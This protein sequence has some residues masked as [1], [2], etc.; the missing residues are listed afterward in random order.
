M[1]PHVLLQLS[2]EVGIIFSLIIE[3]NPG[4]REVKLVPKDAIAGMRLNLQ[5]NLG[6]LDQINVGPAVPRCPVLAC[7]H[8]SK[9]PTVKVCG[10]RPA[11]KRRDHGKWTQ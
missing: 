2:Y 3:K 4:F 7:S 1:V 10:T 11:L 6:S 5:R 9:E 8:V